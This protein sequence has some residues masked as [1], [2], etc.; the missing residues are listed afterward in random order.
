MQVR[1][2]QAGTEHRAQDLSHRHNAGRQIQADQL[3]FR[4]AFGGSGI[5]AIGD[6]NLGV[7]AGP[8]K[9]FVDLGMNELMFQHSENW[10]FDARRWLALGAIRISKTISEN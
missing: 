8:S 1:G 2:R 5:V 9:H 10:W 7:V 4:P 3:C 6:E